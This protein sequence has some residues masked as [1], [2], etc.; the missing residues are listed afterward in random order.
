MG[1]ACAICLDTLTD[2]RTTPCLHVF[3]NVCIKRA[4]WLKKCC[5]ACRAPIKSH[6]ELRSDV[7]VASVVRSAH[8]ARAETW[9]H[10]LTSER[11]LSEHEAG[12]SGTRPYADEVI[13]RRVT[14]WWAE[15]AWFEGTVASFVPGR[16]QHLV[17]YVRASTPL[18]ASPPHAPR[19]KRP[20]DGTHTTTRPR[21][22]AQPSPTR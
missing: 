6:R 1:D 4:L 15:E 7:E 3:C 17:R 22:V 19:R 13:G 2:S 18:V 8:S 11:Q 5:P 16:R 20:P 9:R 14:L 12:E 21:H 10:E